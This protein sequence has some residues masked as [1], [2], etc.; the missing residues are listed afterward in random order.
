MNHGFA[1]SHG[2][3]S[4]LELE[5]CTQGES[6]ERQ[7]E[8]REAGRPVFSETCSPSSLCVQKQQE[9]VTLRE[10]PTSTSSSMGEHAL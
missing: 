1:S 4:E 2:L 6:S 8:R 10:D 7:P 5:S 9:E 3:C